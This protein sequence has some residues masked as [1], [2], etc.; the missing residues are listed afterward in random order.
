MVATLSKNGR[1]TI[2][3]KIRKMLNLKAKD[4]VVLVRRKESIVIKP[5]RDILSLRGV[6]PVAEGQDFTQIRQQTIKN[7]GAHNAKE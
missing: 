4:K 5:A 2:P 3:I 6:V 1:I 7:I